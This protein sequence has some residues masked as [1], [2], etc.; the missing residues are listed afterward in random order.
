MRR[1][2]PHGTSRP[3]MTNYGMQMAID[4]PKDRFK[5]RSQRPAKGT[6]SVSGNKEGMAAADREPTPALR[7][8]SPTQ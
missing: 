6:K 8:L 2:L 7:A 5:H 4:R 3:G 1:D